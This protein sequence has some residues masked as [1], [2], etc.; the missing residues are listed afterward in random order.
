MDSNIKL[1]LD[2]VKANKC[3]EE[4]INEVRKIESVLARACEFKALGI[5]RSLENS[6]RDMQLINSKVLYYNNVL[7]ETLNGI[8]EKY[9]EK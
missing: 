4:S 8:I 2:C 9:K 5:A 3:L 1:A 6:L 7:D